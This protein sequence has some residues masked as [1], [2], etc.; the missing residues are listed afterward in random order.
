MT[1][2]KVL[3]KVFTF[4]NIALTIIIVSAFL[5]RT[6]QL[7]KRTSFGADQEEL[8]YKA[9]ELLSGD[10]VLL[11]MDTSVGGF[12]VGPLFTYLWTVFFIIFSGNPVSGSY[13][14]LFLGLVT[15][16]SA[17]FASR[18]IFGSWVTSFVLAAIYALSYSIYVWDISPW[19]PSLFYLSQI[20][21]ITGAYLAL[22]K[23]LGFVLVALGFAIG[24]SSHISIFVGLLPVGVLWAMKYKKIVNQLTRKY[25]L[26]SFGIVLAGLLP[27][28]I[29]DVTHQ[30]V[31]TGRFL[32]LFSDP[33][34]EVFYPATF[35]KVFGSLYVSS[36]D[37]FIPAAE[38]GLKPVLFL[39]SIILTL[40]TLV[41]SK[42]RDLG[43]VLLL[44]LFV[45]TLAFL[46]WKGNFSEYYLTMITVPAFI[47]LVGYIVD[48]FYKK[49]KVLL[50]AL[51]VVFALSNLQAWKSRS[52]PL[53]LAA[54]KNAVELIVAKGGTSGYGVSLSTMP[55]Y[56]FGYHYLF[57]YYGATPDMPPKKDQKKIFTIVIPPG[58]DGIQAK[59]EYDGIGVLWEGIE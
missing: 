12:T 42:N 57:D 21:V 34:S 17:Y 6:Y 46:F 50:G 41:K 14:A 35:S 2:T 13:L 3:L 16:V 43:L 7:E 56:Q 52:R 26:Y 54:M 58:L 25:V 10:P 22:K 4:K 38:K 32:S 30:F 55:G 31:N 9:I 40:V 33:T 44:F 51:F 39:A 24:F 5:L 20:L 59:V 18:L 8:S 28:I 45:P 1:L 29:F 48:F 15:L 53:N 49:N 19:P 23:P 27:N 37:V 47:F 36:V 11:G